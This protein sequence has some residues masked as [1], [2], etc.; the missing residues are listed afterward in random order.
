MAKPTQKPKPRSRRR[1]QYAA[2]PV[3]LTEDGKMQV[4]LLT[5]R[6]TRRW[7]IPKGW[8]MRKRSPAGAAAREAYEE[9]GLEGTIAHKTPIGFYHYDKG[10]DDG[11]KTKVRV[12]VFLFHVSRQ[13][14]AWPEQHER[15]TQW[16]D[17]QD[18]ADCVDEPELAALL[19]TLQPPRQAAA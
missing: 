9:A 13:L 4:L 2:L 6:G 18:A 15:E 14:Q 10:A 5:S 12:A 16:Y 7:V 19:R 17:P 1:R 3:R 11:S 8:P